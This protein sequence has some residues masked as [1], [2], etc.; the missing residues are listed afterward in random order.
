MPTAPAPHHSPPHSPYSSYPCPS[1]YSW[2]PSSLR[3]SSFRHPDT[4]Y[5]SHRNI[6][7]PIFATKGK[8]NRPCSPPPVR[9][10]RLSVTRWALAGTHV[11][12]KRL[13]QSSTRAERRRSVS[14]LFI[15]ILFDFCNPMH[16]NHTRGL[17]PPLDKTRQ[18]RACVSQSFCL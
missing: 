1:L 2:R 5:R 16:T 6:R 9:G 7:R 11:H 18:S 8:W 17:Y 10:P 3:Q 4:H 13:T 12:I 14:S 15:I